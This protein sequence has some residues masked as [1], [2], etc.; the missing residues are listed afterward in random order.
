MHSA[1]INESMTKGSITITRDSYR[2]F[3]GTRSFGGESSISIVPYSQKE[4]ED[5]KDI[6]PSESPDGQANVKSADDSCD[7]FNPIRKS[8]VFMGA[9]QSAM[10]EA[11]E[12]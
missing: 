3:G 11:G 4:S 2:L 12:T 1:Y 7:S 10:L 8:F 9:A 6:K 5:S